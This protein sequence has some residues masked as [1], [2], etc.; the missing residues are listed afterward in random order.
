LLRRKVLG[1][2]TGVA[3]ALALLCVA[4]LS[5]AKTVN[6]TSHPALARSGP[7]DKIAVV[8]F[9]AKGQLS[10]ETDPELAERALASMGHQMSE[11]MTR[12]G[13]EVIP[14][15][16]MMDVIG[17]RPV[18]GERLIPREVA[19]LANQ[20]YGVNAILI[21]DGWRFRER[22]GRGGGTRVPASVGFEVTL[23][24]APGGQRH[25]TGTFDETQKPLGENVLETTQYPGG[26]MRWLTVDELLHWGADQTV[27]V[28]PIGY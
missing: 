17:G 28:M 5:C 15:S 25:R 2:R 4:L 11:A 19:V 12:R 23:Y 10:R 26:G 21:G 22:S 3:I 13:I 20:A 24:A 27:M 16:D 18:T 9:R 1:T 8:P 6:V 7:I 14:P